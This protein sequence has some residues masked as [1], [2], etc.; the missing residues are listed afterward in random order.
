MTTN[1]VGQ[2]NLTKV[3]TI[4]SIAPYRGIAIR[5]VE[6]EYMK[7]IK[8]DYDSLKGEGCPF[9]RTRESRSALAPRQPSLFES[10]NQLLSPPRLTGTPSGERN[11]LAVG[12]DLHLMRAVTGCEAGRYNE[13]WS[14]IFDSVYTD[15]YQP[16]IAEEKPVVF[17]F[18][19]P[20]FRTKP[21]YQNRHSAFEE[22]LRDEGYEE[23]PRKRYTIYKLRE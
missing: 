14:N 7:Q 20:Q 15:K 12:T 4:S 1:S 17:C 13:F 21:A 22:M 16:I 3:Q 8:A 9:P 6:E 18:F 19:S 2:S 23:I 11:V 5:E 10:R